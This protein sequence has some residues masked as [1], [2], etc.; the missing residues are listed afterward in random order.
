MKPARLYELHH[1]DALTRTPFE[2][3]LVG[4]LQIA[5]DPDGDDL[6]IRIHQRTPE[7]G[8]E[9]SEPAYRSLLQELGAERDE[10]DPA[11]RDSV[12]RGDQIVKELA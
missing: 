6:P 7:F 1:I 8:G 4:I 12:P 5:I 9:L 11:C 2:G 10:L 3:S